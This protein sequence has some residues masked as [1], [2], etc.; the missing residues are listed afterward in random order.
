M[1]K[2]Y[3]IALMQHVTGSVEDDYETVHYECEDSLSYYK[4]KQAA[5]EWSKHYGDVNIKGCRYR[6]LERKRDAEFYQQ[7]LDAGLA[8]VKVVC[9]TMT[10]DNS[11]KPLYYEYYK[12]GNVYYKTY[13]ND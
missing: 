8:M 10:H 2:Y 6:F 12:D 5:E 13:F 9:Y 3:E 4:C 1:K 11:Y 7:P